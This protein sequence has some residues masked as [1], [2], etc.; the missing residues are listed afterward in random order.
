MPRVVVLALALTAL[1]TGVA[2]ATVDA[3]TATATKGPLRVLEANPRYFAD[4]RG[5]PVYL[6]G[7][8]VWW[9]LVGGHTW[10]VDCPHGRVEPFDYRDYLARLRRDNHNFFRLWAIELTRWRECGEDVRISLHPWRR[11]GPGLAVDG[12]PRFD[13]RR[14][15]PAYFT[16]LRRR[17]RAAGAR[18]IYVSVMLFEGWG[19]L[20]HGP[21]RWRSHPFHAPNNVNGVEGDVNGDGTGIEINMLRNPRVIALQE[22]YVR[23]VVDAVYDLDNVLFEIANESGWYSTAWQY[24]MIRVIKR[25]EA[26][27]GR[28]RHPVGMTFQHPHGTNDTLFRSP[29]E[30]ISP[31]G[32]NDR[33]MHDPPAAPARKVSLSDTDHHCGL[34]GDGTFPWRNFTRGHNPIFME[35]LQAN[36]EKEAV[37]SAMGQTRR[38]AQRIDLRRAKPHPTL[39]STRYVLASPGREYLVYQPR[40]GAFT[41]DLR[42]VGT[43][44]TV[45][46]FDPAR[47]RSVHAGVVA[48]GSV[49]SFD[50]PFDGS[51]VLYLRRA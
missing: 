14:F 33:Y 11:T 40:R 5:R 17:V 22:A 28:R 9:N 23:R 45:E 43:R 36:P 21:W 10:K 47:D 32:R 15:D 34:C 19:L 12:L 24:R 27:K 2:R 20:N 41:V 49:T 29:A 1:L 16:R 39:A 30:W 25:Y 26:R 50:P 18:G 48:G 6:T 38:F 8:H 51:A 46:W 13:L 44:F 37:R 31:F 42:G 7:S 4:A 35:D 3:R